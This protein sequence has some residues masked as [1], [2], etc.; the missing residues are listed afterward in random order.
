MLVLAIFV[1][2]DLADARPDR[3]A[4]KIVDGL[5]APADTPVGLRSWLYRR[6]DLVRLAK[7]A[8]G[9]PALADLRN[10][11]GLAEPWILRN[12]RYEFSTYALQPSPELR[13][14]EAATDAAIGRLAAMC[15]EDGTELV[16]LLLPARIQLVPEAWDAALEM[17]GLDSAAYDPSHARQ[18]FERFLDSHAIPHLDL[19]PAFAAA[20]ASGEQLYYRKDR[21]WTA[22][23]HALAAKELA[24]F[25][26]QLPL[27]GSPAPPAGPSG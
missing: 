12:L 19:G 5:V 24:G 9:S 20:I 18:V 4:I 27:L 8:L 14:A 1:G 6:S 13:A 16:A 22:A 11:L 25:L 21:H 10:T 3:E 17:I 23:G 26:A 15:E 7:T 2:N